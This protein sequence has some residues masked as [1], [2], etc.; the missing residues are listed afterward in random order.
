[1]RFYGLS[2]SGRMKAKRFYG[3]AV[4][5]SRGSRDRTML[6]FAGRGFREGEDPDDFPVQGPMVQGPPVQRFDGFIG[7]P[8]GCQKVKT[9]FW[10]YIFFNRITGEGWGAP[11]GQ[12][13]GGVTPLVLIPYSVGTARTDDGLGNARRGPRFF[14]I[15]TT[16]KCGSR[17]E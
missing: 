4:C 12:L 8:E 15:L 7:C 14:D 6:C 13:P 10:S 11:L 16:R 17:D 9:R 3:V 1:M 5:G 2:K